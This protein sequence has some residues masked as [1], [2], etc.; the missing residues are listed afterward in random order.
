M[1]RA[2]NNWKEAQMGAE[3]LL[4][5][6]VIV[7]QITKSIE[8]VTKS[9]N[10]HYEE[11][12]KGYKQL[13]D[14]VDAIPKDTMDKTAVEK[15]A[16]DVAT[17]QDIIDK[18]AIST[19]TFIEQ[20]MKEL[21]SNFNRLALQSGDG[22][23]AKEAEKQ[24]MQ[25]TSENLSARGK[26]ATTSDV[27][28][29]PYSMDQ[30]NKY[31]EAWERFMIQGKDAMS[32]EDRKTLSIGIDPHGG[33]TTSPTLSNRI[34]QRMFETDPI[35]QLASVESITTPELE[36]Y[37]DVN[38]ATCGWEGETMAGGETDTPD[39]GMKKIPVFTMYAKPR[40]S[41]NSLEDSAWNLEAWLGRK[42]GE[43][44]GRTEEAAFVS[45]NGIKKPRGFLTYANGTTDSTV[46]QINLGAAAAVVADGLINMKYHLV[47]QY[48]DRGTWLMHRLTLAAVMMLKYGDGTYIWKPGF[49]ADPKSSLLD[50][51][52]RMSVSMPQVAANAL[53]VVLGD[54]SEAYQIV[55]RL[56]ITVQRD[57]FTVKPLIEFYTRKR[58]GGDMV[59]GQAL[60]IGVISV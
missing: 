20:K 29:K 2:I 7:E 41:Q 4:N 39:I 8:G 32:D 56:G 40:A 58:V 35:R 28:A 25:F 42:V 30:F 5:D 31:C 36:F 47:E 13:K 54:F 51:P 38:Q 46:E 26:G 43:R 11:L 24:L 23:A 1:H 21:E 52:V 19:K 15:I 37:V 10:E 22:K 34:I 33:Y 9:V 12:Q 59:N 14:R 49:A 50:L 57:P 48:L 6:S 3:G 45:G 55:D 44:I 53:S 27:K 60:K 18:N 16:L 17:R